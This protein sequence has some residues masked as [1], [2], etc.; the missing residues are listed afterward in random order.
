MEQPTFYFILILKSMF[1]NISFDS[2]SKSTFLKI[3][4]VVRSMLSIQFA[5]NA[6]FKYV[7]TVGYQEENLLII[8]A[9]GRYLYRNSYRN[10]NGTYNLGHLSKK[11]MICMIC[12]LRYFTGNNF[13]LTT[14]LLENTENFI[15]YWL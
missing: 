3:F 14:D 2:F 10:W 15:Y 4:R 12:V 6:Q 9:I 8:H 7:L 13:K 1:F 5:K 11:K